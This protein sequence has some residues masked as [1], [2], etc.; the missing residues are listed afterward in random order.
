MAQRDVRAALRR[1]SVN[2]LAVFVVVVSKQKDV[3][4]EGAVF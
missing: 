4:L 2:M 1:K 3:R